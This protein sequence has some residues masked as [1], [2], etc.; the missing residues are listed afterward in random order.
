MKILS[1]DPG[2]TT[3]Y[4]VGELAGPR[5]FRLIEVGE[6]E[7]EQRFDLLSI[8]YTIQPSMCV[9]E[10]FILY[11][12]KAEAQINSRFPSAKVI[13]IADLVC[14]MFG[15]DVAMQPASTMKSVSILEADKLTV[16]SSPHMQDAYKH[17]RYYVLLNGYRYWLQR[18]NV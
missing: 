15:I 7:W 17:L 12:D 14:H 10:D 3:G 2:F 11:K 16:G 8:I 18:E 6:L 5:I 4:A 1:I 13:G 9:M